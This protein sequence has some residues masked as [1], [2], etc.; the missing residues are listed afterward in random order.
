M[1]SSNLTS[2]FSTWLLKKLS[3]DVATWLLLC[4]YFPMFRSFFGRN[5]RFYRLHT[6]ATWARA[7]ILAILAVFFKIWCNFPLICACPVTAVFPIL[8][9]TWFLKSSSSKPQPDMPLEK[10]FKEPLFSY[11]TSKLTTAPPPLVILCFS[12][13][14]LS[15]FCYMSRSLFVSSGARVTTTTL[16]FC[17]YIEYLFINVLLSLRL[18]VRF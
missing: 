8:T 7:E 11:L 2:Q 17:L 1:T 15:T 13:S 4:G 3:V 5:P 10:F 14:L 9:W 16:Y 12:T 6:R 18:W